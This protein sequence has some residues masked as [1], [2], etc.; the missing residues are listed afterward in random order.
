MPFKPIMT[1]MATVVVLNLNIGI[2]M[3]G[4]EVRFSSEIAEPSP[5][6]ERLAKQRTSHSRR[7][8]GHH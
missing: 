4:E 7:P 2:A 8:K 1:L 6:Q 3:A 5:F